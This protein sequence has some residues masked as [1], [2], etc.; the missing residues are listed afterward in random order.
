MKPIGQEVLIF[1]GCELRVPRSLKLFF[2]WTTYLMIRRASRTS[3]MI[4]SIPLG[5]SRFIWFHNFLSSTDRA[6]EYNWKQ[7]AE[8]LPKSLPKVAIVAGFMQ[9]LPHS[10]SDVPGAYVARDQKIFISQSTAPRARGIT[11]PADHGA[12]GC[13]AESVAFW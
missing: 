12:E 4:S 10:L 2:H 7:L 3:S 13:H 6:S 9:Q 11:I 1:A 8:H 5:S